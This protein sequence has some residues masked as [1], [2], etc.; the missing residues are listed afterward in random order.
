MEEILYNNGEDPT[1]QEKL[2]MLERGITVKSL[3]KVRRK[4]PEKRTQ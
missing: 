2:V 1:D 3:R 4:D